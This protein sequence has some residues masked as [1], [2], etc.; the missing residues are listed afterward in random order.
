LN[1]VHQKIDFPRP[2]KGAFD[3]ANKD[4][5]R[6]RYMNALRGNIGTDS[7]KRDPSSVVSGRVTEIEEDFYSS[8]SASPASKRNKDFADRQLMVMEHIKGSQENIHFPKLPHNQY[9]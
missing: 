7:S 2:S 4:G 9:K 5:M 1:I 8:L 3:L 6:T